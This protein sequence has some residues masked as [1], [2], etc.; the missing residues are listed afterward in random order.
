MIIKAQKSILV[1]VAKLCLHVGLD[2][3]I[4][5]SVE[6]NVSPELFWA[7]FQ[8]CRVQFQFY[9]SVHSACIHTQQTS[10]TSQASQ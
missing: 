2:D 9:V 8:V 10:E 6:I 7:V 5:A 1:G 3:K 4:F